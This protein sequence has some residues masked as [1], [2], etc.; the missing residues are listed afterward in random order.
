MWDTVQSHDDDGVMSTGRV[1]TLIL[2]TNPTQSA[3]SDGTEPEAQ[4]R[5]GKRRTGKKRGGR[6]V[7]QRARKPE[8]TLH[9]T[10]QTV[11]IVSGYE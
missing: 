1:H 3:P 11:T 6:R 7:R 10:P 9:D 5:D 4:R 8:V 2:Q